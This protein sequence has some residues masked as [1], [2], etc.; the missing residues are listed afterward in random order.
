MRSGGE[1]YERAAVRAA[2]DLPPSELWLLACLGGRVPV[3]EA[4]LVAQLAV[5]AQQLSPAL[6]QL[7]Q[8][9]LVHIN[10]EIA[11][12]ISGRGATSAWSPYGA[13]SSASCS[14]AGTRTSIRTCSG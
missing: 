1:I 2:V 13:T 3:T 4:Q 14:T 5:D 8:K 9:A 6:E 7:R 11:L 12:T 10:G